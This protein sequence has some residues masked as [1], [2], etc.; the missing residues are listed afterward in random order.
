MSRLFTFWLS[1]RAELGRLLAQH[2]VL[3]TVSTAVAAIVGVPLG[4]FAARDAAPIDAYPS[5]PKRRALP[6]SVSSS[7][8]SMPPS[9]EVMCL[10]IWKL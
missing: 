1:H 3:V 8:T 6:A 7:V 2:V 10:E 4:I 5:V 9:P